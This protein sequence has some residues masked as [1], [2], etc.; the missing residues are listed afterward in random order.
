MQKV[1]SHFNCVKVG[2]KILSKFTFHSLLFIYNY[3]YTEEINHKKGL[4]RCIV[5]PTIIILDTFNFSVIL[6]NIS[7]YR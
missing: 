2:V 6:T 3:I 5:K 4:S 1:N 7:M